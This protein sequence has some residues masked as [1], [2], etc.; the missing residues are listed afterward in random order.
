[1]VGY[2]IINKAEMKFK[3]YDVYH[4]FYCGLCQSLKDRYGRTGQ[5]TLSYDMT[6]LVI[7]LS[8]LYEPET[9]TEKVNCVTHP[10]EKHPASSNM[11]TDYAADM[12]ILLS[13]YKCLDDWRD[14]GKRSSYLAARSLHKDVVRLREQYP[15]KCRFISGRLKKLSQLEKENEQNIDMMAGLFGDI[16]AEVFA[17]KEDYWASSLRKIGFFLGKFV[18]LMDAYEDIEKDIKNNNYNPFIERYNQMEPA[19]FAEGVK[20]MLTM[21]MAEC[22]REFEKLPVL[23]YAEI[24]RNILYSGVWYRYNDVT[25]KRNP[26][27]EQKNTDTEMTE[28]FDTD[29]GA[30]KHE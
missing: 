7:L 30:S 28:P 3:D 9:T 12:N 15:K 25:Q 20:N 5:F 19:V 8:G 11:Y 10:F 27:E 2:V 1:M 14:E 23:R 18:Y 17:W 24:L 29:T 26:D 4:A 6:F 13:Y 22:S 16:M 21:M